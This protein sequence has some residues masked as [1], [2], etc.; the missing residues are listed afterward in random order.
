[1]RIAPELRETPLLPP[2]VLQAG[3][4]GELV[5]FVGAGISMLLNLP[6]WK[7]LAWYVLSDLRDKGFLNYSEIEQLKDLDPK[8][9]LSIAKLIAT[10]NPRYRWDLA[11]FFETKSKANDVYDA[12][13][14][15]G[16]TCVTTNYDE[17]LSPRFMEK[18]DGST[19]SKPVSR[20]SSKEQFFAKALDEP[21]CVIHIHGSIS[22]PETMVVTTNEYLEHYDHPNI[23]HF[24]GELF[25]KK[26]VLFLGYGLEEVEILEYI[27]RRGGGLRDTGDRRRFTLQGFFKSQEPLY[28]KL[29]EYYKKSFGVHVVGFVR[30]HEN[31]LQQETILRV[32]APQIEVRRPA[33]VDELRRIQEVLGG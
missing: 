28:E 22:K 4:N 11:Q 21:G 12:I 2:E 5:L 29:Y 26:T 9:Q 3:L 24:L 6:S 20:I 18:K 19:T 14:G 10:E 15:I 31:Y 8:K 32:W 7:M 33:L 17:L 1:M 25:A 30:D 23:K 27:L 13:N 16:C